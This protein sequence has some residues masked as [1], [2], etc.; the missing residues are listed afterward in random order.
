[1]KI[2]LETQI[3]AE[4]VIV[5]DEKGQPSFQ[6]KIRNNKT[7]EFI[8]KDPHLSF[9]SKLYK[10]RLITVNALE[11]EC[12][13]SEIESLDLENIQKLDAC[14]IFP[15]L[16]LFHLGKILKTSPHVIE[17]KNSGDVN[18]VKDKVVGYA[19]FVF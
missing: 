9:S 17:Y 5:N 13:V 4:G 14:G 1:M 8:L 12:F 11:V 15:L 10:S 7:G 3:E 2:K 6:G 19:A 18:G 16:V